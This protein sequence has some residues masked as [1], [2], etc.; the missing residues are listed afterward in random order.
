VSRRATFWLALAL[1]GLVMVAIISTVFFSLLDEDGVFGL[2]G[3]LDDE[4]VA[5]LTVFGLIFADA[6]VPIFPGETAPPRPESGRSANRLRRS[7]QAGPGST[8]TVCRGRHRRLIPP[9]AGESDGPI[10]HP[11]PKGAGP[12]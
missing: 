9:R 1:V 11:A 12:E 4:V 8:E 6:I 5:Y 10:V 3:T 2:I 7:S